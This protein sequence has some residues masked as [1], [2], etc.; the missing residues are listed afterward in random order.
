MKNPPAAPRK[1]QSCRN[2]PAKH[3]YHDGDE[4]MHLC[5]YCLRAWRISGR[6]WDTLTDKMIG[7]IDPDAWAEPDEEF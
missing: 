5:G 4:L 2:H 3:E 7:A 1:C 6:K